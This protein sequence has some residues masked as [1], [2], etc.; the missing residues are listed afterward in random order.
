M[1]NIEY[2]IYA[3]TSTLLIFGM[4]L[5]F[6]P[7][8]K[9]ATKKTNIFKL[10]LGAGSTD[11]HADK[12][13][14]NAGLNLTTGQYN[15]GRRIALILI[16]AWAVFKGINP[17][18]IMHIV[19]GILVAVLL[20]ALS[21]PIEKFG[22]YKSPFAMVLEKIYIAKGKELDD[23]LYDSCITL[24]NLAIVQKEQPLSGDFI[25]EQLLDNS[26][27]LKPIYSEMLSLYR[28][29]KDDE[30]FSLFNRRIGTKTAKNFA[31]ILSKLDK[32][33]PNELIE[34]VVVFQEIVSEQ[35]LTKGVKKADQDS[36]ITTV[37]ATATIFAILLNFA[38]VVVFM[39][40]MSAMGGVF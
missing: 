17:I 37:F 23:E 15:I 20:F 7:S 14:R 21:A 31:M 10:M 9:A 6:L 5:V 28:S 33:N 16:I 29:G 24:K 27:K 4:C 12:F 1:V 39:D 40:T 35:R 22:E 18:N 8:F 19:L 34:Q 36:I 26:K 30:A 32:I 11:D 25:L 2:I 38:V 3:V 13:F